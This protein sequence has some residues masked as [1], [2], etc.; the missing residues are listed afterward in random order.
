MNTKHLKNIKLIKGGV[1]SVSGK[2][3]KI[4]NPDHAEYSYSLEYSNDGV[5]TYSINDIML[6]K[7][8]SELDVLKIDIEGGEIDVFSKNTEWLKVTKYIIIELH[9]YK[10]KGC[11]K[12]LINAIK[13]HNYRISFSGENLI[14][15]NEKIIA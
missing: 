8:W 15:I 7:G 10:A 3:M 5:P 1:A 6:E 11:S 9:D 4:S 14:L 13:D 2:K 12:A